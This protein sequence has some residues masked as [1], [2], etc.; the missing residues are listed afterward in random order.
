MKVR[1]DA[2]GRAVEVECGDAGTSARE[3]LAEALAAWKATDGAK[4]T[5]AA[6]GF[7]AAERRVNGS[8]MSMGGSYRKGHIHEP[9]AEVEP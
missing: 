8:P 4:A 1:I 3:V 9:T 2:G 7:V 5:E 6:Y